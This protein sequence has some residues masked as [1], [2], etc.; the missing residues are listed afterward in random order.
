M[1]F[2]LDTGAEVTV[3][4]EK[5][6]HSLDSKKQLQTPTKRLCGPDQTPLEVLGEIPVTLAY[7][8]RSCKHPV[9]IVKNLQQNLLGL[10]AIKSLSLLTPIETVNTPIPEQYPS[11]FNGLGTFPECYEIKLKQDAQPFALFTPRSVPLPLR[12]KV[13]EELTRME[14]LNVISRVDKPSQWCAAMVVVPK[15]NSGTV[16]ICVDFRALNECVLREV[17]PLPKVEETLA[18]LTG[19]TVF[20]KVDAG[21]WQIPLAK[22]SR[23]YTTFVTPFGRYCFN[24]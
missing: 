9:F 2:K 1:R 4:G 10:P 17:H 14:S 19:A 3:V 11:L 8:N 18:Q 12:K 23:H 21:F 5:V 24:K 15:R 13:E 6:L 16:R 22:H 7:K 20:S